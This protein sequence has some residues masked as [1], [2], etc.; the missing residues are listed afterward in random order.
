M[1]GQHA[2]PQ[3]SEFEH[4]T[5]QAQAARAF[6]QCRH[7]L[8]HGLHAHQEMILKIPPHTTQFMQHRNAKTGQMF[9]ISHA[10]KLQDMR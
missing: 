8:H 2:A 5:G 1:P 9:R 6:I 10:R 4:L 3:N 7:I